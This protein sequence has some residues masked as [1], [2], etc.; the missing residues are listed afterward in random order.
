MIGRYLTPGRCL[1]AVLSLASLAV[2]S[3]QG[4][5]SVGV[6]FG[7]PYCHRPCY[8]PYYYRPYPIYI[9]PAERHDEV[10]RAAH[11][12]TGRGCAPGASVASHIRNEGGSG[13][14]RRRSARG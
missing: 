6:S 11:R 8:A 4:G 13:P 7:G 10:H 12:S 2:T 3:A 9:R 5:W 14:N 1:L